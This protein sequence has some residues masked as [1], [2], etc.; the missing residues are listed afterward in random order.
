[1]NAANEVAVA[2]F[3]EDRIGY[4]NIAALIEEV[5]DKVDFDSRAELSVYLESDRQAR[6]LA[7]ELL[8][9]FAARV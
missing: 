8:P 2:A 9:A 1:M 4:L 3:L 7:Q 6:R 5:M